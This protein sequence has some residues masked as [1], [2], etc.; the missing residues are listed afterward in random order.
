MICF[1]CFF[2]ESARILALKG[3]DIICHPVN[4]VLPYCREAMITDAWK[5][6]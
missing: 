3:A 6:K 2:P 4:L 5:I 1:D